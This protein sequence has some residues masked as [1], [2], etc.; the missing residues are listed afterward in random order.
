MGSNLLRQLLLADANP[1]RMI[2]HAAGDS[3]V[4]ADGLEQEREG[5]LGNPADSMPRIRSGKNSH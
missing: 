2:P 3:K 1:Q 5:W 4:L